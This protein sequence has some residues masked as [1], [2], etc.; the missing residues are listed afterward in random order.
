MAICVASNNVLTV[1]I[2]YQ[3]IVKSQIKKGVKSNSNTIYS[4][5]R[6]TI[7]MNELKK[8]N[9]EQYEKTKQSWKTYYETNKHTQRYKEARSKKQKKYYYDHPFVRIAKSLKKRDKSSTL[10]KFDIWKIARRQKLKCALTGRKLINS[11]ISPD[12]IVP[13]SKGGTTS[14]ENIRLVIKEV[15]LCR[16]TLSDI[17]FI[18]M[19]KDVVKFNS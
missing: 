1:D 13:L 17:D 9:P 14:L 18:E 2:V 15:N 12:H 4:Y 6:K 19:C 5:M 10:T 7:T 3:R 16:Q 8:V 11:N